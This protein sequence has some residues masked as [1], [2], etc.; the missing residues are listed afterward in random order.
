MNHKISA[1]LHITSEVAPYSQTGGLGDVTRDLPAMQRRAGLRSVVISP[2][3]GSVNRSELQCDKSPLEI[4]LGG[5]SF[6]VKIWRNFH[7]TYWFVDVPG[8][9]DRASLYQDEHGDYADNPLRFAVFCRVAVT[10]SDAFDCLHLHDWQS[11]LAA[12]YNAGLKPTVISIHNLA[13]QGLCGFEWADRLEIP[14]ELRGMDGVEFYGKVSLL[15][16]GLVEADQIATVSPT[17]AQE[18]QSEPGGQGL[19]GLFA[20]RS[21]ALIGILNGLDYTLWNPLTDTALI[22]NFEAKSP[23][24]RAKNRRSLL[25]Q[26]HLDD[27]VLFCIVSRAAAQK[28]LHLITEHLDELVAAGARFLWLTNGEQRIMDM[29]ERCALDYPNYFRLIPESSENN[30]DSQGHIAPAYP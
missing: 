29:L 30:S 15:K 14:H 17:Y 25:E 21:N 13:Y 11:G 4:H 23:G 5:E 19:S 24:L 28:G 22:A 1:V 9:L 16:A 8:L 12:V 10:L 2:L 18:I 6:D 3:Y 20:H 26:Y 7:D 27:G